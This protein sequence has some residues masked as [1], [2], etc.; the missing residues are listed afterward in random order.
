MPRRDNESAI[1]ISDD[2]NEIVCPM[3]D[4]IKHQIGKLFLVKPDLK[5][6]MET[7]QVTLL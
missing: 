2:G 5:K 1:L 7:L 3:A 6:E 4:A